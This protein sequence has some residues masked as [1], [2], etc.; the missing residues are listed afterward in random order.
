MTIKN[1]ENI[2][3][4]SLIADTN[5]QTIASEAFNN[6]DLIS[7][8]LSQS[9]F[10]KVLEAKNELTVVNNTTISE[11][12][13]NISAKTA[14]YTDDLLN[15]VKNKDLDVTGQKLNEVISVA[16]QVN[17]KKLLAENRK[18]IIGFIFSKIK[19]AKQSIQEQFST[20]KD[21]M[22]NLVKEVE[23]TQT[24]LKQRVDLL[25]NMFTGVQDEYHVLGVYIAA[26]QLRLS[27]IKAHINELAT[28]EQSPTISQEIYD[29]NLAAN[30]LDKRISDLML[31][32]QSAIQTLPM[33]RIIQSNNNMLIDKFYAVKNI[34][35]PAWKNQIS[36]ALAL[37]EQKNSVELA[38]NIDNATNDL[39]KRNADLL[40]S[41]SI[42]TAKANQRSVIDIETLEH[43]QNTL[44][45]TVSDV[46]EIQ[47]QGMS[48]RDKLSARL[49]GL[50]GKL[51]QVMLPKDQ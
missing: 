36:L 11:Y 31:L 17:S 13:K 9:D 28:K 39:L 35:L 41:N 8:G 23:T 4:N 15:F 21:Q 12:G 48:E 14:E 10:D 38:N 42:Q 49:K 5:N 51:N 1:R 34:T 2:M 46:I 27:D 19:G 3:N 43:V 47:K 29:L 20:T 7:I 40:H 32:Q 30:N 44:I 6:L 24:G 22:D 26:G 25:E 18:G 50:Q 16:Q 33:I 37:N 45:K